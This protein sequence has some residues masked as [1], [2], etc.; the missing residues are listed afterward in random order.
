MTA[1]PGPTWQQRLAAAIG[2]YPW[3][4]VFLS[5]MLV[6]LIVLLGSFAVDAAW[7]AYWQSTGQPD[8]A[9]FRGTCYWM[10]DCRTLIRIAANGYTDYDALTGQRHLTLLP[11]RSWW[12][13]YV[14]L[15]ALALRLTGGDY[16]SG[17]LVNLIAM[18]LL[19]PVIQGITGTRRPSLMTGIA[20]M[21]FGAW[22]YAGM[23][24]GLFLLLSGALLWLSLRRPSPRWRA[25]VLWGFLALLLGTLVGLT[26][27]N[28][29]ALIP[30]FG[31]LA[32][33]RTVRHLE[34]ASA[35]DAPDSP[36]SRP[37]LR[38]AFDDTN[39]GWA[40]V[41]AAIGLLLGL[42]L[43]FYQT[44]GYY[45]LYVLMAQRTLWFKQFNS[46]DPLALA[47]YLMQGWWTAVT[48]AGLPGQRPSV[49]IHFAA[50][51]LMA[52][53]I[54]R[55]L[56]PRWP[57]ADRPRL[58]PLYATASMLT[59][60]ATMFATGQAHAV[61]RYLIGNV[62]FAVAFLRYVYG[63]ADEPPLADL[64]RLVRQR[65]GYALRALLRLTV[66]ACS[67]L[68]LIIEAIVIVM[69]GNRV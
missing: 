3:D 33:A 23:A 58:T 35:G 55:D 65:G 67:L 9:R 66:L 21:P 43:W 41:L 61:Q 36:R 29:L 54:V 68:L 32:L 62:F 11:D 22:L 20:L 1:R 53:L 6:L 50:L 15:T 14:N 37:K 42:G 38:R 31:L 17:W 47:S 51:N 10:G 40:A 59:V 48:G 44:S 5:M 63:D 2:G 8:Y 49:M 60:L 25:R 13:L 24:E 39:P 64:P 34:A 56:P 28:A 19:P 4:A 16:C 57:G 12:P 18:T 52:V 45:P 46:G 30:G 7:T 27:P 26:K 69:S